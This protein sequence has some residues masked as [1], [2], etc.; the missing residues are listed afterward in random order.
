MRTTVFPNRRAAQSVPPRLER[1]LALAFWFADQLGYDSSD[2]MLADLKKSGE[3]WRDSRNCVLE[4]ILSRA[5][6]PKIAPDSLDRFDADIRADLL[7]INERREE[8]ISLKYFQYLAALAA[9]TFLDRLADS[10]ERFAADLNEFV[11][12][13]NVA[14]SADRLLPKFAPEHLGKLAFWM[15]TGSGKTLLMHINLRQ[16]MR[17][18]GPLFEPRNVVLV[19]PNAEMTEQHLAELRASDI[20]CARYDE[21][22]DML[23]SPD[24]VRVVDINKF[25]DKPAKKKGVTIR[26]DYFEGP[27]LVFVDEGHK[28]AGGGDGGYFETRDKLARDGGFVFEYSATFGQALAAPARAARAEEYA[29]AI[30]FDYSYRHFHGDG[31]GKDFFVLNLSHD[32]E[33]EKSD[34]I[35]LGN[36]LAFFQ[37][38]L[39]YDRRRKE[40]RP[41]NVESPLLLLLGALVTG[42]VESKVERERQTDIVQIIEFLHRALAD[43]KWLE[44]TAAKILNGDSGIRDEETGDDFFA[45]RFDFLVETFG[46]DR[47]ALCREMRRSVF[48]AAAPAAL[49]FCPLKKT[50]KKGGQGEIGLRAGE[51]R[52]FGLIYV[53]NA[54]KLRALV[55]K[56]LPQVEV[57]EDSLADPLFA[58]VKESDSS[59]NLLVGAKKFMEGWSSWR[60]CGI[61]LLN[62]GRGEGPQIIQLFGR[63]VRLLG[64]DRSLRRSDF[65]PDHRPSPELASK[66]R[67][68]ET[69]NVF[70][71]RAEF[72][73]QFRKYLEREGVGWREIEMRAR[74]SPG[75][76]WP[77]EG[78][79]TPK[80]PNAEEFDE[81]FTLDSDPPAS[82]V[83][84]FS[85]RAAAA[86]G[87]GQ[88][89]SAAAAPA[90]PFAAEILARVDF[91]DLY[92]RMLERKAE[93]ERENL[94]VRREDLPGALARCKIRGGES[95]L[96]RPDG[97]QQAAFAALCKYAD[98]LRGRF[99]KRWQ[100]EKMKIAPLRAKGEKRHPNLID[101]YKIRLPEKERELIEKI[102]AM[103]RDESLFRSEG[104]EIPRVY[105]DRHLY[106]PL[107]RDD[108]V[109]KGAKISP[110][111]LN[112]GERRFVVALRERLKADS[113]PQSAEIFLLRNQPV[114]GVGFFLDGGEMFYPDFVL[115]IKTPGKQRVVFVDPHGMSREGHPEQSGKAMLFKW[116]AGLRFPARDGAPEVEV[117]SFIVSPTQIDDLRRIFAKGE[118]WDENQFA[119]R[120]ILFLDALE[121]PQKRDAAFAKIFGFSPSS[122]AR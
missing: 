66:L 106:L 35:M 71:V 102:R 8:P 115:W 32:V 38:R 65:L 114:V 31:Y 93:A 34:M 119:A 33:R 18:K 43:E 56:G 80:P 36:L 55:E 110:V 30:A 15:A 22:P 68:L 54:A 10:K 6:T 122:A 1:R 40:L 90:R 67:L 4:Q 78:L 7:A 120:H 21:S 3:G 81:S 26:R 94:I 46:D 16:F 63:G 95:F 44:T 96:A 108:L 20:P 89:L 86:S 92:L 112:R 14:E 47:A 61:G 19:T 57:F 2:E 73:A 25:S 79:Q 53:G 37:Q 77:E 51:G 9:E 82:T 74:L 101:G 97:P 29:R 59:V 88:G 45:R 17:R 117:D 87:D 11:A 64:R 76:R 84:D 70:A 49:R 103:E 72:M 116:L 23:A 58:R 24:A 13:R 105:F 5:R 41:F 85:S 121:C 52:F 12:R 83:V 48:H 118:E 109:G 91:D 28:G 62:V 42:G 69:L 27:N 75:L 107:L 99:Q 98:N 111:G 104:G 100:R 50:A 60:V 113:I 39:A